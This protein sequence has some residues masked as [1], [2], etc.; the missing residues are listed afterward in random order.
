MFL[1]SLIFQTKQSALSLMYVNFCISNIRDAGSEIL[2]PQGV[3]ARTSSPFRHGRRNM[4]NRKNLLSALSYPAEICE[5]LSQNKK[6]F[7][8]ISKR[9]VRL[10]NMQNGT[11]N[12]S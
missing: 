7:T 12:Y 4:H 1:S 2:N 6:S 3:S 10:Q 5:N 8:W 11:I 9:F